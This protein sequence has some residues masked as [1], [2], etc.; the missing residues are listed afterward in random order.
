MVIQM[1]NRKIT[2]LS[3]QNSRLEA[4][5]SPALKNLFVKAAK[6]QGVSLTDFI[7]TTAKKEAESVL[8]LQTLMNLSLRDMSLLVKTY[9]QN[10][11]PNDKLKQAATCFKSIGNN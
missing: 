6:I 7:V 10:E 1:K 5:I 11:E 4:R 3:L 9:A 2:K 8:K